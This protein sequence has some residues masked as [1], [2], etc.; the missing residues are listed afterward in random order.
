MKQKQRQAQRAVRK[1]VKAGILH[2]PEVCQLCGVQAWKA[3]GEH[4][5]TDRKGVTYRFVWYESAD[6][7][8]HHWA[9][10][11]DVDWLNVWWICESCHRL[12]HRHG[13]NLT[14]DEAK[15]VIANR[16]PTKWMAGR[17]RPCRRL[18]NTAST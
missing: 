12:L 7:V 14:L 9:G 13:E 2:R 15:K 11:D 18:P 10:Y 16:Q 1:A 6:M 8:A 5:Y 17:S 4:A 3:M